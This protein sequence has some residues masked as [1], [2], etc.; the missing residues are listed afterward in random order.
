MA[1][2]GNQLRLKR[3]RRSRAGNVAVPAGRGSRAAVTALFALCLIWGG[4]GWGVSWIAER[5]VQTVRV[6]G[7]FRYI[8][9]ASVEDTVREKLVTGNTYFGVPLAEIRQAVTTIPWVAEASVERRWP[10]RL[11][12]DVREHRPV[13]RWGDTDF[14][15]DR[16]NRF[17]VG[18][19][20]G[21][22]HLPL[23]AGPDG[24]ERRLVKVLI[25]LDERFE[26]WGTRVA[27]LRLTDRWSWSL[28]LESDLRVEFGRREPVEVISSLLALL[29]LLGKERMALLQSIDL[30][31]PYGF[32]VVWKTYPPDVEAPLEQ[33]GGKP[34]A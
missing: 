8:D 23:L 17:H 12:V 33:L 32:A 9:P 26:S 13:A 28:R 30:R 5:R 20:R 10:D 14:I 34:P 4:V 11:E 29:P 22:E 18:S 7:A 31:Y 2:P 16:M 21:F 3:Q 1:H 27:E 25:A 19:T 15:D 24:Q 6:K